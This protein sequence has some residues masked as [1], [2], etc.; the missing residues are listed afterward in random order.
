MLEKLLL[1]AI[2]TLCLHLNTK[3]EWKSPG[4]FLELGIQTPQV[5]LLRM[6]M[7]QNLNIQ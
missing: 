1:A 2:L 3:I 6:I 4:R 7:F 5:K